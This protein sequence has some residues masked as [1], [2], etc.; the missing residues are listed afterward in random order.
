MGATVLDKEGN[1]FTLVAKPLA[2]VVSAFA[3]HQLAH[4]F[5]TK[6]IKATYASDKEVIAAYKLL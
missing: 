4:L 1:P 3:S 2:G 5:H 6:R